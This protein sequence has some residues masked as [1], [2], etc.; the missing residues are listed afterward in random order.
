MSLGINSKSV[1]S[2]PMN[3]TTCVREKSTPNFLLLVDLHEVYFIYDL[4]ALMA[5]NPVWCSG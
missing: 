3:S 4:F 5:Y 2:P 1:L